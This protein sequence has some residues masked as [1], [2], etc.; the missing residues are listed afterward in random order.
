MGKVLL[1]RGILEHIRNSGNFTWTPGPANID[2]TQQ[3]DLEII[4]DS[5]P[6]KLSCSTSFAVGRSSS[7]KS[8][9]AEASQVASAVASGGFVAMLL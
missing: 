1:T 2:R 4:D 9:I 7:A 5:D 3:S 6:A 8:A